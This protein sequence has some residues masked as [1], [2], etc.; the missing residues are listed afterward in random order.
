MITV[1]EFI[2]NYNLRNDKEK[3]VASHIVND[4]V[5]YAIKIDE[6]NE[7]INRTCYKEIG[8]KKFFH[9]NTP[10][11]YFLFINR[12]IAR[13]TDIEIGENSSNDFD[14]LNKNGLVQAI[15]TAIPTR[16]YD[17]WRTLLQMC[18]DDLMLNE[19]DLVPFLETKFEAFGMVSD[20]I[21]QSLE[22]TLKE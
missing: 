17:E 8:G 5:S 22:D 15:I 16:E 10:V 13:Y 21:N 3:Y 12:L 11:Q 14:E 7:I 20:I 9:K 2:K 1:S 18:N 6:C 4:Y 19:R